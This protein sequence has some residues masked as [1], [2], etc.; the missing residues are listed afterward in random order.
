MVIGQRSHTRAWGAMTWREPPASPTRASAPRRQEPFGAARGGV[1]FGRRQGRRRSGQ[2]T[3]GADTWS[4][5]WDVAGMISLGILLLVLGFL[6]HVT[7]LWTLG[8]ILVVVGALL[9]LLGAVGRGV[10]GRRHFF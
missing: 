9:V 2:A 10:A 1:G 4:S 3:S 5:E 7:L 6:S 8:I